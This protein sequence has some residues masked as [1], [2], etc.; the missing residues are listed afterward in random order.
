MILTFDKCKEIV[1]A[2]NIYCFENQKSLCTLEKPSQLTTA[3]NFCQLRILSQWGKKTYF[4][5]CFLFILD[6]RF[7]S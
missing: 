2:F 5:K 1:K 4:E 7:L 6:A 3:R